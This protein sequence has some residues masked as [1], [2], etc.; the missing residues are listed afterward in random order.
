[1][2]LTILC[3]N[4]TI[5]DQ[6]Y[7]GEPALSFYIEEGE[8][9]L[10]FD[11]GYSDVFLRNAASL[12]ID[13]TQPMD[14]VLSHGHN[15]HTRGLQWLKEKHL[16]ANKRI[17]A[18][19]DTFNQK[20]MASLDIG[21]PLSIQELKTSSSLIL[22]K[23]PLKLN[24]TMTYLGEIPQHFSFEPRIP[25]G[26]TKHENK[27]IPDLLLDD[28]ALVYHSV[29]GLFIITGCSHSGICNIIETAKLLSNESR[30]LGVIGGFHLFDVDERLAQTIDYLKSNQIELL[31]PCHC[32]SFHA[33]AEIS[34]SLSLIEVGSGSS[35]EII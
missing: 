7:L 29:N 32:V 14:I 31:A 27:L 5:I 11:T 25:I 1:M 12:Q 6:Y 19:P 17:I 30:I 22:S 34:K 3:D 28:S 2:K 24:E 35:L 10:L 8:Q 4:N 26:M 9:R 21:S 33:K 16:L 18:H 15:D 23:T 20:T 13:L